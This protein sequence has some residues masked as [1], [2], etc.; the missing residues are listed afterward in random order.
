MSLCRCFWCSWDLLPLLLFFSFCTP[1]LSFILCPSPSPAPFPHCSCFPNQIMCSWRA[2]V[3][4]GRQGRAPRNKRWGSKRSSPLPL[5]AL[6]LGHINNF[7]EVDIITCLKLRQGMMRQDL[8]Q[9]V[10]LATLPSCL[11]I[12]SFIFQPIT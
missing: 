6:N 4:L 3:S 5:G 11:S 10:S 7:D 2:L 9:R 1:G 12:P 8:C